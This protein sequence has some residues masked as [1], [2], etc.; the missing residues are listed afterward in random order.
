ME[1]A[2]ELSF[3][4]PPNFP[5][6]G[7]GNPEAVSGHRQNNDWLVGRGALAR[8]AETGSLVFWEWSLRHKAGCAEKAGRQLIG[9]GAVQGGFGGTPLNLGE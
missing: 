6:Y 7:I 9:L 5:G 3:W 8:Y 1:E 2:G 4:S